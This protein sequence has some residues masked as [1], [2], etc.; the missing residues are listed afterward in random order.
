MSNTN[1]DQQLF[2]FFYNYFIIFSKMR[3]LN[4]SSPPLYMIEIHLINF[5]GGFTL[6]EKKDSVVHRDGPAIIGCEKLRSCCGYGNQY[7]GVTVY[8]YQDGRKEFRGC[9]C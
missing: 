7:C 1:T 4:L 6:S 5:K 2:H 9:Y 8:V 3:L